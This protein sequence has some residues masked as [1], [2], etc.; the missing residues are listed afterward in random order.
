M[1]SS[2]KGTVRAFRLSFADESGRLAC[3]TVVGVRADAELDHLELHEDI[4]AGYHGRALASVAAEIAPWLELSLRREEAIVRALR[5]RHARLSAGLLQPGLFDRRAE[6][7]AAAQAA[8]VDEAMVKSR[9][10]LDALEWLRRLRC[11]ERRL[12][13]EIRFRP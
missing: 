12:L 4:V 3:E 2:G 8:R 11:G 13:F 10:R 6:R 5:E 9:V 7:A 1:R